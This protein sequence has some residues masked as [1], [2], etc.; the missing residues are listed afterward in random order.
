M[1]RV[2]F[3]TQILPYP[4]DAGPKIRAYYTLRHLSRRH[5]ITLVSLVRPSDSQQAIRHLQSLCTQVH[6]IALPRA[7]WRDAVHWLRSWVTTE[8]FLIARDDSQALRRLLDREMHNGAPF[9]YIHA[10]QLWMAPY[11]L[12]ARKVAPQT[13][14]PITVLDQHNAVYLIPQRLAEAGAN[15]LKAKLLQIEARRMAQYE[16]ETCRRFDRVVWVSNEDYSAVADVGM[17]MHRPVPK[18]AVIPIAL[19]PGAMPAISLVPNP[20][21]ITFVG[22]L[23]WPPNADGMRWFLQQIWPQIHQEVPD[24]L[25][26]VVGKDPPADLQRIAADLPKVEVTGYAA[27]LTPYLADTAVFIV[28][29]RAG[30]GM[31]VKILDAW[32]WGLPVVSTAIGAEG[33]CF[34]PGRDAL[35]ADSAA[36]FA[37][38]TLHLLRD[39]TAATQIAGAGQ[40]NFMQHYHWSN[41]YRQW[42][43]IY[44]DEVN[45]PGQ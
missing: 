9:D 3:L 7:G 17:R 5:E 42:D 2:L 45:A 1:T 10:D 6:T 14:R 28:P 12:W 25:L 27:D 18:S 30:G 13:S 16:V 23:H 43:T 26:T 15:P 4:L 20:R 31:R 34:T 19:D 21:R 38:A 44:S 39:R 22:G 33:L 24:A 41:A 8:P 36:D 29:L 35:I 37:T 11:A 32:K 40:T